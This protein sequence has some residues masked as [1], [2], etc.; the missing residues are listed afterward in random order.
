MEKTQENV[1]KYDVRLSD[2]SRGEGRMGI[3]FGP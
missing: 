2:I 3:N 1:R